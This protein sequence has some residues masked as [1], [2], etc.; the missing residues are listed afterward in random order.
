MHLWWCCCYNYWKWLSHFSSVIIL[1][2]LQNMN[3]LINETCLFGHL[4]QVDLNAEEDGR[5]NV[6]LRPLHIC[7]LWTP[8][9]TVIRKAIHTEGAEEQQ[10]GPTCR[11]SSVMMQ[12]ATDEDSS[13]CK[14][15]EATWMRTFLFFV[16]F[17]SSQIILIL[18]L[19]I[20]KNLSR[21]DLWWVTTNVLYNVHLLYV[22]FQIK[23]LCSYGTT[24]L[25]QP[26]D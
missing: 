1:L 9:L 13:S 17:W 18:V 3:M 16:E 20:S 7:A 4:S 6:T 22:L 10:T 26:E 14:C 25:F 23:V 12:T 15:S 19:N 11:G 5:N 8:A 2:H 21:K 24:I